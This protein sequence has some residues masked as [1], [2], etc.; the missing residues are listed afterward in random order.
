[1]MSPKQIPPDD[2]ISYPEEEEIAQMSEITDEDIDAMDQ[3]WQEAWEQFGERSPEA[4][5]AFRLAKRMR[6]RAMYLDRIRGQNVQ[7]D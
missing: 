2:Y 4:I 7:N 1:M 6:Y 5:K 3:K